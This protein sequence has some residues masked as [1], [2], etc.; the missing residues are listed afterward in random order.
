[1]QWHRQCFQTLFFI[2]ILERGCETVEVLGACVERQPLPSLF[3]FFLL[4]WFA[5]HLD[6]RFPS[7]VVHRPPYKGIIA[8]H[9]KGTARLFYNEDKTKPGVPQIITLLQTPCHTVTNSQTYCYKL[10]Q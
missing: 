4:F 10:I 9:K 7:N 3:P 2:K 6:G 5:I 8:Y 1:M